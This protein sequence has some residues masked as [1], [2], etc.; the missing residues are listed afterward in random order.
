MSTKA[1]ACL[2][3]LLLLPMLAGCGSPSQS[4]NMSVAQAD[5]LQLRGFMPEA[6][7]GQVTMALTSGGEMTSSWWGSSVSSVALD[8][9]LEDSLRSVGLWAMNPQAARYQLQ[10]Q[11]LSLVQPAVGL[12]M[13]VSATVHYTL[14]DRNSGELIYQ[15][16]VRTTHRTEFGEAMLSPSE[17]LR[18]ANEGAIRQTID[19]MLRDLPNLGL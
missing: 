5:A 7:R 9:A 16:S 19:L 2:L 15:R 8:H 1:S 4:V 3:S 14:T 17:R 12:D 11:L 10:A 6:L 18:L 13:T